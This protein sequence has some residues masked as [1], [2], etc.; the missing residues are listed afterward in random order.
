MGNQYFKFKQFTINQHNTAMKVGVDAVL[1]GSWADPG[2]AKEVLDIGTGTGLLSL[3]LAQKSEASITAIDIDTGSYGQAFA[4]VKASKW[5]DRIEVHNISIQEFAIKT[6]KRFDFIICNPPFFNSTLVSPDNK[7][8]MARHDASLGLNELFSC[9]VGLLNENGRFLMIYQYDRKEEVISEATNFELYPS[10]ALV[11]K[12][13][14]HKNPNRIVFEFGRESGICIES[15]I[16]IRNS[17]TNEYT[18][19]YKQMTKDY[20]LKF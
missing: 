8:T 16:A 20:Y 13:N 10:K 2:N 1:L 11:I 5:Y 7:R 6:S 18:E 12:G 15:E 9:V 14:E 17:A 3:M 4:N 19:K